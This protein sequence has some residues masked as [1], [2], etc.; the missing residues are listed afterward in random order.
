[1]TLEEKSASAEYQTWLFRKDREF[2]EII[3]QFFFLINPEIKPS[4]S[5]WYNNILQSNKFSHPCKYLFSPVSIVSMEFQHWLQLPEAATSAIGLFVTLAMNPTME[6][7]TK[8][9]NMLVKELMQQT[10]TE[11]LYGRDKAQGSHCHAYINS[12]STRHTLSRGMGGRDSGEPF[13][14]LQQHSSWMHLY[15]PVLLKWQR[16]PA[17]SKQL[18]PEMNRV[19]LQASV[20][21]TM[22]QRQT[23]R[24]CLWV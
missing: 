5:D 15:W 10:M 24:L 14:I 1:M 22:W 6:K 7:M 12:L 11:S 2:W 18:E 19:G 8:P 21:L 3:E 4:F 13:C 9:A 17:V 16:A 20:Y 23:E